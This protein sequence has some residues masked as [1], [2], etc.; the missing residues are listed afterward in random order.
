MYPSTPTAGLAPAPKLP[1][2]L[3]LRATMI[4]QLKAI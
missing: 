2:G 1:P 4:C 3:M